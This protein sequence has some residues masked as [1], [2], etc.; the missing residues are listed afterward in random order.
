M[1]NGG[2]CTFCGSPLPEAVAAAAK[3]GAAAG[4][5]PDAPSSSAQA[6]ASAGADA[7]AAEDAVRAREFA[8]RLL[9][10]DRTSAARTEVIDDQG[11]YF[12]IDS[13]QWLDAGERAALRQRQAMQEALEADRRTRVTVTVDLVGREARHHLHPLP[14]TLL[15]LLPL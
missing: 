14:P 8:D 4:A 2:A 9:E 6:A 1:R 5:D 13:N 10:F 12:E 11:D 15:S 3:A 7:A